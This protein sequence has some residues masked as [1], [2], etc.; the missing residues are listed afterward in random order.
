MPG[1]RQRSAHSPALAPN[2]THRGTSLPPAQH[3]VW[4][5]PLGVQTGRMRGPLTPA[6]RQGRGG[7][8][9]ESPHHQAQL[10]AHARGAHPSALVAR[11]ALSP[12]PAA[13]MLRAG[14]GVRNQRPRGIC[15]R[16]SWQ[17]SPGQ[18]VWELL[19]QLGPSRERGSKGQPLGSCPPPLGCAGPSLR[20]RLR[21]ALSCFSYCCCLSPR[22]SP[23]LWV[24]FSFVTARA[25]LDLAPSMH[26][27][28]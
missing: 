18:S 2:P 1:P 19:R 3:V 20:L 26:V 27:L 8:G 7:Q 4:R 22:G 10:T 23:S 11:Q 21:T 9:W 17:E 13:P 25:A 16:G 6:G 24:L 14:L 28:S 12:C 5:V 15:G